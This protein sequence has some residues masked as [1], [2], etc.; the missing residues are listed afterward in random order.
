MTFILILKKVINIFIDVAH[1]LPQE[2]PPKIEINKPEHLIK[3]N[4]KEDTKKTQSK[5][6]IHFNIK[7]IGRVVSSSP[8]LKLPSS[9][10]FGDKPTRIPTPS[11]VN[12]KFGHSV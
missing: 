11:F 3:K 7:E 4:H 10:M 1:L 5:N 12:L 2:K 6:L 8:T 9:P